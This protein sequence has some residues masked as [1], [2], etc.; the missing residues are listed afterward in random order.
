MQK[1]FGAT[2]DFGYGK[3]EG[4]NLG[5]NGLEIFYFLREFSVWDN[6]FPARTVVGAPPLATRFQK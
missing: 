1:F 6:D 2:A 3:T 4:R 5:W